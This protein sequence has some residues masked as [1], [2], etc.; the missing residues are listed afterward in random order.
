[1]W[2]AFPSSEYYG[3]SAS[4]RSHQPAGALP[5][6]PAGREEGRGGPRDGSHVHR[7]PID[8]GGAQLYPCSIAIGQPQP[9]PWPRRQD[10]PPRR[11]VGRHLPRR[12]PC[13]HGPD[14][15]GL[16]PLTGQGASTTG[17]VSLH[18]PVSLA[19]PSR[20]AVPA[21]SYVVRAVPVRSLHPRARL[22]S[23]SGDRC[24]GHREDLSSSSVDQRLVAHGRACRSTQ[25]PGRR[26]HRAVRPG[27]GRWAWLLPLRGRRREF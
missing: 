8:G 25:H 1:M 16:G 10:V 11:R 3:A 4:S 9:S 5:S 22:P 12:S 13:C 18:L 7:S 14:P 6:F 26:D 2:T 27:T 20:L 24:G 21:R 15:P 19:D 23:A 17:S